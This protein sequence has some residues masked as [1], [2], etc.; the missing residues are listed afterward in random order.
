MS[1]Q[2]QFFS[3][4]WA[5]LNWTDWLPLNA[6]AAGFQL[7]PLSQPRAWPGRGAAGE[8]FSLAKPAMTVEQEATAKNVLR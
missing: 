1:T 2:P 4:A 8:R 6:P 5:N 7:A 3:K